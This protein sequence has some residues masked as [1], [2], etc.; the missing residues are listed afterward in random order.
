[1]DV[2]E[3]VGLYVARCPY[4]QNQGPQRICQECALRLVSKTKA[5]TRLRFGTDIILFVLVADPVPESARKRDWHDWFHHQSHLPFP[6]GAMIDEK[7]FHRASQ[8]S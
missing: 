2:E 6:S 7:G 3:K 8:I 4:F 1:M 5:C